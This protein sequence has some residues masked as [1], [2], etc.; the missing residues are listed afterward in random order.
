MK[1]IKF[2][3]NIVKISNHYFAIDY[4]YYKKK[5]ISNLIKIFI[6][7]I[8]CFYFSFSNFLV[9]FLFIY[10][11]GAC[12]IKKSLAIKKKKSPSIFLYLFSHLLQLLSF[13]CR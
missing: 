6:Y 10:N 13:F 7:I 5:L 2:F 9:N 4:L 1:V 3:Y 12:A 8:N 11:S